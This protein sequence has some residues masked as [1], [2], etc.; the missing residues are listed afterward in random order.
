FLISA[1]SSFYCYMAWQGSQGYFS[2]A[3][4]PHDARMGFRTNTDALRP[5]FLEVLGHELL[6]SLFRR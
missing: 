1:F 2:S 6:F 5:Y 4:S 3:R